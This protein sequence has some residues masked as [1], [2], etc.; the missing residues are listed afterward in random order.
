MKNF[1][2]TLG[3]K[4]IDINALSEQEHEFLEKQVLLKIL[5]QEF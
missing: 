4:K 3:N 5:F 1:Y 2:E